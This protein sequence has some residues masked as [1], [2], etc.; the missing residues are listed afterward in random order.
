VVDVGERLFGIEY[1]WNEERRAKADR[2]DF[3]RRAGEIADGDP[4]API[5]IVHGEED[6]EE[7][8]TS[9]AELHDALT[10]AYRSP[11]EVGLVRVPGLAHPLADEPGVAP[12]PQSA[13]AAEADAAVTGWL[14]R[15]LA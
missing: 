13:G 3:V 6:D 8:R 15:H 7:L 2:L 10:K 4:Q 14:R 12:A 1:K 9:S 11:D 5:L